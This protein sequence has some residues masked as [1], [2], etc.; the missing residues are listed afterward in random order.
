MIKVTMGSYV[1]YFRPT[2]GNTLCDMVSSNN[3]HQWSADGTTWR[4]P[5]YLLSSYVGGSADNWPKSNID[6]D[7]RKTL[8][9]WGNDHNDHGAALLTHVDNV[10]SCIYS[11]I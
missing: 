3:K 4:T 1:D 5:T 8:P 10:F 9:F 6:G 7:D 11:T 2:A